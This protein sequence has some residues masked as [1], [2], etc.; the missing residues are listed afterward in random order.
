MGLY[1]ED[2][3]KISEFLTEAEK[4]CK[5]RVI[6][7]NSSEKVYDNSIFYNTYVLGLSQTMGLSED[8]KNELFN[9]ISPSIVYS[10]SAKKILN[11][12]ACKKL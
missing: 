6:D 12:I 4:L 10:I 11:F 5:V 8:V 1:V 3:D 7:Y 9:I 2:S